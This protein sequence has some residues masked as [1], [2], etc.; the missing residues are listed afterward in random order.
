MYQNLVF[1]VDWKNNIRVR[2]KS[3]VQKKLSEGRKIQSKES[4]GESITFDSVSTFDILTGFETM[5]MRY[6]KLIYFRKTKDGLKWLPTT[7]V[8]RAKKPASFWITTYLCLT[9]YGS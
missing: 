4:V 1:H 3:V 8:L 6:T 7:H 5:D 9:L 2:E